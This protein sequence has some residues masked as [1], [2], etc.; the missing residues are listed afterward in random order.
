MAM[1]S[2]LTTL[3]RHPMLVAGAGVITQL[4]LVNSG[5]AT[6]DTK[7]V[8]WG[9]P[10]AGSPSATVSI[11][12]IASSVIFNVATGIT[13]TGLR[14]LNAGGTVLGEVDIANETFATAGTYTLTK[15]E[16]KLTVEGI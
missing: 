13:V 8:T 6:V 2:S 3:V 11:I 5:G 7:A 14:L 1:V 16:I 4:R 9:S 10:S 12:D 15:L